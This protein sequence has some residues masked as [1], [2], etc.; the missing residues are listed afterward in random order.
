MNTPIVI[1]GSYNKDLVWYCDD[2]PRAGETITGQFVSGPGGKGSNQAVAAAR[3]GVATTFIGA[4]G[5]DIFGNEARQLYRLI[6][7]DTLI[8]TMGRRGCF[9]SSPAEFKAIP[10]C[11]GIAAVDTTGAGDAYVG[12]FASGWVQFGEDLFKA[13]EY[14]NAVAALSVTK[15]GTTASM[16]HKSEIDEFLRASGGTV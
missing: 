11:R 7:T 6:E 14:A 9:V 2:F 3:T 5:H 1:V 4:V 16:P 12:G 15:P 10:A 13:A 8:I